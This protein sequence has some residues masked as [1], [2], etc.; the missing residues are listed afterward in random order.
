MTA[1]VGAILRET[2][3]SR[4][5]GFFNVVAESDDRWFEGE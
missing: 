1:I 2:P 5:A 4:C 3:S